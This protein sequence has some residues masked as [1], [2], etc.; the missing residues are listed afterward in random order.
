MK[1]KIVNYWLIF[2]ALGKLPVWSIQHPTKCNKDS[3]LITPNFKPEVLKSKWYKEIQH[4]KEVFDKLAFYYITISGELTF[5]I[6]EKSKD[7]YVTDI[8]VEC[9]TLIPDDGNPL[10]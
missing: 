2:D 1:T 6:D 10:E 7:K 8:N 3:Y 5:E 4:L 9:I